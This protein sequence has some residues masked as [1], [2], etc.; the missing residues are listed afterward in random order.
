M[1]VKTASG[2]KV[3]DDLVQVGYVSGAYGIA[4]GV[5]ITPFSDDADALLSVKTWWFDKP[6]LHDVQVR[7]AKLHGGDVVAQLVGVVGRDAAEALKGV[8][9]QIPRSHFP[10]LTADEF[11]WSDLIGLT[12]E[13][14][15]GECLGTVHDMM[16]NGPQSILRVTPVATADETVEKAPERLIPF[17]GQF[18]INVD[19][20]A[21]KITVDWGLDY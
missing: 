8:S 7:Q 16:S 1:T 6:T 9:V 11:Y 21:N 4:G 20:A 14:L 12:V 5:R 13:N 3:P 10:T 15:Q 2:V 17:V 19:K 18:V